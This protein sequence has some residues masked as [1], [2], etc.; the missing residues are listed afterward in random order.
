MEYVTPRNVTNGITA[1]NGVF[2]AVHTDSDIMQQQKNGGSL[3]RLYLENRNTTE[4]ESV[5]KGVDSRKS[6]VRIWE[7]DLSEVVA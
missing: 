1:D 2:Y 3:E 4:S 7:T 6:A 5:S